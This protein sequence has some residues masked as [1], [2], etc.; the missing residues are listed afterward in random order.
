MKL[1]TDKKERMKVFLMIGIGVALVLFVGIFYGIAPIL[2]SRSDTKAKIV[3]LRAQ[4]DQAVK[5]TKQS[6]PDIAKSRETLLKLKTTSEKYLLRPILNSYV[7]PAQDV[8]ETE[9]KKLALKATV[10]EVS[11]GEI[12]GR[13]STKTKAYTA[14]VS[15]ECG[16]NQLVK[17]V[18]QIEAVNPYF[19]ITAIS[20]TGQPARDPRRHSVTFDVQW[21]TWGDLEMAD[22]LDA[23]LEKLNETSRLVERDV[24]G[25]K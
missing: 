5:E 17:L 7:L 24:T 8:I 22:K 12:P 2:K 14:H 9:T 18:R 10:T 15:L 4:L 16:Y 11:L 23:Q 1:P 13:R 21:P 25:H 3:E 6:Q 20:I 19:C